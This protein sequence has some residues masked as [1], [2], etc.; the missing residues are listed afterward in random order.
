MRPYTPH[1]V[2]FFAGYVIPQDAWYLI[3]ARVVLDGIRDGP[4]V[5]PVQPAR[6]SLLES[7]PF[8]PNFSK[9]IV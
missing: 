1:N 3:P 2:D 7:A 8:E 4:M 5:C 9:E 6:L